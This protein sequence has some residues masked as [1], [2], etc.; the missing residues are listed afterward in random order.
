MKKAEY[1]N[2]FENEETHFYYVSAHNLVISLIKKFLQTTNNQQPVTILDAGCGTGFLAK[3]LQKFGNVS[4]V[5]I[6]PE[7]QKLV[8]LRGVN[9]KLASVTKLPFRKNYFDLVVS[10]DVINH[11]SIKNIDTVLKEF[12]RV[13]K[14]GGIL[15]LKVSGNQ[16]L[17]LSHDQYVNVG[18]RLN[19]DELKERLENSGFE[20]IK[21]SFCFAL[22]LIPAILTH[23]KEKIIPPQKTASYVTKLPNLINQTLIY[24]LSL[25]THILMKTDLPFGL[26]LIAVCKK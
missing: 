5:D 26:G 13:L 24:L 7:A 16:W 22:L 8:K 15:I 21:L 20:I 25:E 19:K 18:E 17:K 23:F 12:L 3:K 4:A 2:I 11:K 9:F 10:I 1:K 14:P 6:S